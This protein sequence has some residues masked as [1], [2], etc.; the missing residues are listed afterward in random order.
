M[1]IPASMM[2]EVDSLRARAR[3]LKRSLKNRIHQAGQRYA[4][5]FRGFEVQQLLNA[6]QSIGVTPG[7]SIMAHSSFDAFAGF[8]GGALD[9]LR[10]LQTAVGAEGTLMMPTIPFTGLALEYARSGEVFDVRRTPSRV[11]L[12]TE[13]MRRMPGVVRSV[14]PT[15]S[16]AIWGADAAGLAQGHPL[17]STPCGVGSPYHHLLERHGSIL[18]LGADISVLTFVHTLEELFEKLLPRSPFTTE[19]FHLSSRDANGVLVT[20][21]T[22]LFDPAIAR[23]RRLERLVQPLKTHGD[24]RATRVGSLGM[25]HIDCDSIRRAYRQLCDTRRYCYDFAQLT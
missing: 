18:L 1:R 20:T 14:H 21:D 7:A 17:A 24:W 16:V 9:V 13:L 8:H 19:R 2:A 22:R 5:S 25:V 4:R 3:A 11:G 15:H 10:T 6:L 12:L 23:V